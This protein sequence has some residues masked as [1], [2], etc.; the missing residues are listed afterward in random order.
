MTETIRDAEY[1]K[2]KIMDFMV[3]SILALVFLYACSTAPHVEKKASKLDKTGSPRPQ[4]IIDEA[5]DAPTGMNASQFENFGPVVQELLNNN[6]PVTAVTTDGIITL[7]GEKMIWQCGLLD[8]TPDDKSDD[9]YPQ[10]GD[11]KSISAKLGIEQPDET[12]IIWEEH[13]EYMGKGGQIVF[14]AKVNAL[15][16]PLV[17]V[18][19]GK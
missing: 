2:H 13:S 3:P 19:S 12:L 15:A 1:Y 16:C 10:F 7:T 17:V 9:E 5:T 14:K 6:W 11:V 18:A 4:M 8:N